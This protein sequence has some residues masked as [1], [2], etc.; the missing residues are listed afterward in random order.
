[1]LTPTTNGGDQQN[2]VTDIKSL[3]TGEVIFRVK[4]LYSLSSVQQAFSV[5]VVVLEL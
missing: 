5:L 1:M 2:A 3:A 4:M